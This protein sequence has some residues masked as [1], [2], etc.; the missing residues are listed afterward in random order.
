MQKPIE[1]SLW[2]PLTPCLSISDSAS[3]SN[4]SSALW[5]VFR[6]QTCLLRC[7][8][9]WS[10]GLSPLLP[11]FSPS[12]DIPQCLAWS[13]QHPLTSWDPLWC[14]LRTRHA[15]WCLHHCV[16]H[17]TAAPSSH[18]ASLL[19]CCIF[20]LHRRITVSPAAPLCLPAALLSR[21]AHVMSHDVAWCCMMS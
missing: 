18:T 12:H 5:L 14:M 10:R 17:C 3:T 15:P 1:V 7:L 6:L 11:A 16:F 8:P 9:P 13:A 20:Q 21:P 2:N 19:L 4:V